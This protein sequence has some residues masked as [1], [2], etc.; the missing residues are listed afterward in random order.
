MNDPRRTQRLSP[1][2]S[3]SGEYEPQI[4]PHVD[5]AYADEAPYAATYAG[6]PPQW[7]PNPNESH[8]TLQLP[9]Y[10]QEEQARSEGRPRAETGPPPEGPK[11]PRWLWILTVVAVLLA[12]ALVIALVLTNGGPKTETAVPP[13][14]G[15]PESSS[16]TPSQSPAPTTTR[17]PRLPLPLPPPPTRSGTPTATTEPGAMQSVVYNVSG[18][19][20]AI[21]ITWMDT[22]DVIQTEFNVA[23]PWSKE[24]SLSKSALHPASV[25]IINIGHNVTCSLTVDGV[26]IRQRVG[27]GLTICNAP[28]N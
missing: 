9:A 27:V 15:M 3:G 24:V 2:L 7:A 26:Q 6:P 25:T 20:R 13:L 5:P 11:S 12:V 19:G 4:P 8:P 14:P 28:P 10:W 16:T 17:R 23:L 18:D 21:S 22:G 1:P